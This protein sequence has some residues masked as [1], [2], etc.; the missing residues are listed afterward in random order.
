VW[1]QEDRV[2]VTQ[3]EVK[4]V[5]KRIFN[6]RKAPGPDGIVGGIIK[7]SI[8][9]MVNS[10]ARCFSGC[11]ERGVFLKKWKVA[12]LVLLKKKEG[13]IADYKICRPICLLNESAKL[14]ERVIAGRINNY[15]KESKSLHNNQFGFLEGK[16]TVDAIIK[17]KSI[18]K[19]KLTRGK[20]V[21]IVSFDIKIAFNSIKWP[22]IQDAMLG[23]GFPSHLAHIIKDYLK[24]RWIEYVDC[25]GKCR[26]RR[27]TCGVPQG[28]VLG[29]ILWNIGYNKVLSAAINNNESDI[30]CYADDTLLITSGEDVDT[31]IHNVNIDAY[32]IVKEI[33]GLGL[34]V[35]AQKTQVMGFSGNRIKSSYK[36]KYVIIKDE[37]IE[38]RNNIKYLGLT[39]DAKWS[40]R[41]HFENISAKV[42]KVI[43][44]LAGIMP[45]TKGPEIKI[46]K[47]YINVVNSILLYGAPVW[48]ERFLEDDRIVRIINKITRRMAQRA[49]RAYRTVL[50]TAAV[51]ISGVVPP[52]HIA[53]RH[54]TIYYKIRDA[55]KRGIKLD[56][57][58][59]E[60]MHR[61]A[62][63]DAMNDWKERV[64]G[65][66]MEDLGLRVREA[67][68]PNIDD[69]Y[70]RSHGRIT[71]HITQ[72]LSGHG[73][74]NEFLYKI[75]K[76]NSPVC[77][78]CKVGID[79]A[80]HTLEECPY[81]DVEREELKELVG[82]D[83]D[84]H[85]IVGKIVKDKEKWK[86]FSKFCTTVMSRKK[87]EERKRQREEMENGE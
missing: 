32:R 49:N 21:T 7:N 65:M 44:F 18:V 35:A 70:N 85:L 75:K 55:I 41:M 87:E 66:G 72:I 14:L 23:M 11:M 17:A 26:K 4:K 64:I 73:C 71:Y 33:E 62:K 50:G 77:D 3:K 63:E 29:P 8:E 51:L 52:E 42:D 83:L 36:N 24:D 43:G 81:W 27:M 48:H 37:A 80:R 79:S 40:F 20:S 25:D 56:T 47:L 19:R 5:V 68:T 38:I 57:R 82:E 30:I 31:A 46:R 39:L 60:S 86:G 59:R 15:L 67:I 45:N 84:L 53:K 10:W 22:V 6:D 78:Q 76:A 34:S 28:S 61:K 12:K 1:T 69:C 58:D 9:S 16:S 74:F 2:T 13:K 54:A